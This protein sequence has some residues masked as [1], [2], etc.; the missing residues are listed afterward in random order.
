M[1]KDIFFRKRLFPSARS[2]DYI[3]RTVPIFLLMVG[4]LTVPALGD[5]QDAAAIAALLFGQ[6]TG[7]WTQQASNTSQWEGSFHLSVISRVFTNAGGDQA[8]VYDLVSS[9][10]GVFALSL[11]GNFFFA[12]QPQALH[13]VPGGGAGLGFVGFNGTMNVVLAPPLDTNEHFIF[14]FLVL[15]ADAAPLGLNSGSALGNGGSATGLAYVPVAEPGTLT[16][17]GVGLLIGGVTSRFRK[18]FQ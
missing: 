8:F 4:L 10:D 11:P 14:S 17:L 7:T 9:T 13:N 12:E 3:M 15:Q 18:R 5:S 2:L 6:Y 16:L 1:R